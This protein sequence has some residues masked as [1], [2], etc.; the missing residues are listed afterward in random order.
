MDVLPVDHSEQLPHS[1]STCD[2]HRGCYMLLLFLFVFLLFFMSFS[3]NMI[4]IRM[5]EFKY[6]VIILIL[7][8]LGKP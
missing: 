5:A 3:S 8:N 2:I 7:V 6:Y 4:S 1:I